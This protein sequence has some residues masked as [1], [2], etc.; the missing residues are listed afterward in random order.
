VAG[1]ELGKVEIIDA[2][3]ETLIKTLD[4]SGRPVQ[5]FEMRGDLWLFSTGKNE[6]FFQS[7]HLDNF[8]KKYMLTLPIPNAT[9][10]IAI[11]N[12]DL[13]YV[14]SSSGWPDF[15]DS[16]SELSIFS[17]TLNLNKI[18]GKGIY[19][20]GYDKK[21]KDLILSFANGFQGNGTIKFYREK[22]SKIITLTVGRGPSGFM[23][24][25]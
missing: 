16:V 14:T 15:N 2:E 20:V 10:R 18:T 25:N 7:F 5:F 6:I 1:S 11:G 4:V 23:F 19:G 24:M 21:N 9:G 3:K 17:S 8:T 22:D 12:D 13:I